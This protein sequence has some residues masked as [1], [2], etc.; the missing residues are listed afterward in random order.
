MSKLRV[1][2]YAKKQNISSKDVIR[3][4]KEYEYRSIKSYVNN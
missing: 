4:L 3:K 1:Y 2:E